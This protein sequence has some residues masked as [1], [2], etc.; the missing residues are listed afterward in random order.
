[1][2]RES[3]STTVNATANEKQPGTCGQDD[4]PLCPRPVRRMVLQHPLQAPLEL[5]QREQHECLRHDNSI[6]QLQGD[7]FMRPL[8]SA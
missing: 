2:S 3:Q 5:L 8:R 1:M 6:L 7:Q 4:V